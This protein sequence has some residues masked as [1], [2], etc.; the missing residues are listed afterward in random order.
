M[1][2]LIEKLEWAAENK[3]IVKQYA[4]DIRDICFIPVT[5]L[6]MSIVG[7]YVLSCAL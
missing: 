7:N 1:E 2:R 5:M 4:K 3:V 6:T